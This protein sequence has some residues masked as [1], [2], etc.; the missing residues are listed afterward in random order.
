MTHDN[1]PSDYEAV[2]MEILLHYVPYLLLMCF[3][4]VV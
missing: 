4:T 3:Y 2:Y 1:S